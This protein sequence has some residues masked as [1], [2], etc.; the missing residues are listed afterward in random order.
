MLLSGFTRDSTAAWCWINIQGFCRSDMKYSNTTPID[1]S[2]RFLYFLPKVFKRVISRPHRYW[3][4][5]T[6]RDFAPR[7]GYVSCFPEEASHLPSSGPD[8]FPVSGSATRLHLFE[9]SGSL[10]KISITFTITPGKITAKNI[11][12]PKLRVQSC[13][14]NHSEKDTCY[15][16]EKYA[17]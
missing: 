15:N 2:K 1:N 16:H 12:K 3:Q 8:P 10:K 4:K 13:R 17:F 11:F 14:E 6:W 9:V 7:F 5:S